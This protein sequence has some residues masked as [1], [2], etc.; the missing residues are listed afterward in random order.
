MGAVPFRKRGSGVLS[1]A[2]LAG[3]GGQAASDA[4]P[5]FSFGQGGGESGGEELGFN[6]GLVN[7]TARNEHPERERR[8][9][10][11]IVPGALL[12]G[13]DVGDLAA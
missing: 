2:G 10:E 1:P 7:F 13:P 4:G 11:P 6:Q 12:G 5:G 3:P 9:V 8:P